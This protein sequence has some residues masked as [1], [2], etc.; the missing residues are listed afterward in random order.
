MPIKGTGC[1]TRWLQGVTQSTT[2]WSFSCT[3]ILATQKPQKFQEGTPAKIGR[4]NNSW[5]I[6][7][8]MGKVRGREGLTALKQGV[9]RGSILLSLHPCSQVCETESKSELPSQN[10]STQQSL[11]PTATRLLQSYEYPG[12]QVQYYKFIPLLSISD[13]SRQNRVV[14]NC[15]CNILGKSFLLDGV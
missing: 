15:E 1:I 10:Y 3:D 14:R 7:H 13:S 12:L 4:E 6:K 2:Y 8:K 9:E 5:T 11:F